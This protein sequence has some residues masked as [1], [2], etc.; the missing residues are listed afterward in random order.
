MTSSEGNG[1]P[2]RR[3]DSNRRTLL[4]FL[5]TARKIVEITQSQEEGTERTTTVC[6]QGSSLNTSSLTSFLSYFRSFPRQNLREIHEIAEKSS[7]DLIATE[8]SRLLALERHAREL[9]RRRRELQIEK[10]KQEAIKQELEEKRYGLEELVEQK[11]ELENE[12]EAMRSEIL[13]LKQDMKEKETLNKGLVEKLVEESNAHKETILQHQVS[14]FLL[15]FFR[16][17]Y[18]DRGMKK[19]DSLLFLNVKTRIPKQI[20][21]NFWNICVA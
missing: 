17:S 19:L 1:S 21:I 3:S 7:H 11:K 9:R 5:P 15:C 16:S 4:N 12:K 2:R 6:E 14:P 18:H 13:K 20:L 8:D 10:Q